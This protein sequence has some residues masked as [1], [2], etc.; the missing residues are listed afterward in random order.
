MRHLVVL[1]LACFGLTGC[2]S[3]SSIAPIGAT[4]I[5]IKTGS[6]VESPTSVYIPPDLAS[7]AQEVSVSGWG[8]GAWSVPVTLGPGLVQSLQA[9]NRKGL[10]NEVPNGSAQQPAPGAKYNIAIALDGFHPHL[11]VEPGLFSSTAVAAADVVLRVRV[12]D[13][14]AKEV[15]ISQVTGDGEAE[16]DVVFCPEVKKA[17]TQAV[18]LA[19][20]QVAQNYFDKVINS[21]LLR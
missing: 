2:M 13:D 6:T 3:T 9:A 18:T 1:A 4:D 5:D 7:Y 17:L 14:Q 21:G 19:V 20:Q 8:C 16:S 12:T 15:L 11:K 10:R